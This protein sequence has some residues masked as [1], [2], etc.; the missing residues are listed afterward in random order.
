MKLVNYF[1][2]LGLDSCN[3]QE[4]AAGEVA[5]EGVYY[6]GRGEHLH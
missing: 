2:M 3:V 1:L 5:T 6:E 4:R